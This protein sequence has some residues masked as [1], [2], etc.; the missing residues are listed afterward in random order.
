M[1]AGDLGIWIFI[2]PSNDSVVRDLEILPWEYWEAAPLPLQKILHLSEVIKFM[3]TSESQRILTHRFLGLTPTQ[4]D[5][6]E[7]GWDQIICILIKL[8]RW[9]WCRNFPTTLKKK[10][11]PLCWIVSKGPFSFGTI[12]IFKRKDLTPKVVPGVCDMGIAWDCMVT[13]KLWSSA[14]LIQACD[15]ELA[16]RQEGG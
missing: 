10:K 12:H 8:C 3:D 13:S 9:C 16:W 11:K 6:V 1:L 14:D 5:S 7:L 4:C 2:G 15:M